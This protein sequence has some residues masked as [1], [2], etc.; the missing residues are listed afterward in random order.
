MNKK[1]LT[2]GGAVI[3]CGAVMFTSAFSAL[4][5][6]TAG[7]EALKSA[8]KKSEQVK[9]M[10]TNAE[11][12]VSDNDKPV[13]R[14]QAKIKS[15]NKEDSGSAEVTVKHNGDTRSFDIYKNED[16]TV[17]KAS[18]SDTYYVLSEDEKKFARREQRHHSDDP[19]MAEEAERIV[20]ALVGHYQSYFELEKQ[21]DGTKVVELSLRKEEI[22]VVINAI[23]SA[24]IRK[25]FSHRADKSTDRD[26]MH[27]LFEGFRHDAFPELTSDIGMSNIHLEAVIGSGEQI[28]ATRLLLQANG[29]DAN[30]ATHQVEFAI[31]LSFSDL[32]QTSI[33]TIQLD[34]KKVES[35]S[36]EE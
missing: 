33:D 8:L 30:G 22:P 36:H 10:T 24:I 29:K 19:A 23:G 27:H 18:D 15:N 21:S 20:D 13:V 6:S 1:M 7:Y 31:N 17:I 32:N 2:I 26:A 12:S 16:Q 25:A 3:L 35:I 9:S 34:G 4:A 28:E 11:F 14:I 5:N